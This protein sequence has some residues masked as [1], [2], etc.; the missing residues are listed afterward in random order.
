MSKEIEP[1]YIGKNDGLVFKVPSELFKMKIGDNIDKERAKTFSKYLRGTFKGLQDAIKSK[2]GNESNLKTETTPEFWQ[3]FEKKAKEMGVDLIGYTP[4]NPNFI[5]KNMRI[6][7]KNAIVLGQ[8][9]LWSQIKTAP[10]VDC[11]IE[12]FRVY[13]ELGESTL[14]LTEYLKELGYKSEAHHPFGGN[15]LYPYHAVAAKLGIRGQNGL[16]ITPEFGPR[17]RWAIITTDADI[18]KSPERDFSEMKNFCE[19]CGACVKNCKGKAVLVDPIEKVKD[20]GVITHIERSK[21]IE[22]LMNNNFCSLC[23]KI[24]SLGHPKKDKVKSDNI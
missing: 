24:C 11:G 17:Q 15:L 7:G 23:L 1:T 20:S 3:E 9:L 14:K 16:V 19:R 18:P 2:N 12:C 5:F 4:V 10:S 21:C 6:Y 13:Q 8:E 22:S